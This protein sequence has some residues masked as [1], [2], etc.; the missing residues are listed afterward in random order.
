MNPLAVFA[1]AKGQPDRVVWVLARVNPK[2]ETEVFF[3]L[4]GGEAWA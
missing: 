4:L 3:D 2:I 1:L